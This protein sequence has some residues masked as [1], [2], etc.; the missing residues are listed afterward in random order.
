MESQDGGVGTGRTPG[1]NLFTVVWAGL[2]V[3]WLC[4]WY[5]L[6]G[7]DWKPRKHCWVEV[8]DKVILDMIFNHVPVKLMD[9]PKCHRNGK[10]TCL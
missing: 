10:R 9:R 3:G 7:F 4:L 1:A 8:H 5:I 2:K 6:S